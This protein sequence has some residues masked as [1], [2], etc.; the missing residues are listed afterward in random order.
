MAP[1]PGWDYVRDCRLSAFKQMIL[2][3]IRTFFAGR[4]M[5]GRFFV[6]AGIGFVGIKMECG[7]FS[8]V[9]GR[10]ISPAGDLLCPR[11][12]SRQNAAGGRRLEKH[13]V[14]LC[15]LPRTPVFS[16]GE[17]PRGCVSPSGAGEG[18]DTAP[19]AARCRS[20][21]LERLFAPTRA[22]APNF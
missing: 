7:D 20:L 9:R 16:T 5:G 18:Q 11:R 13:S 14:F 10:G 12:Q 17:P 19:R 6:V 15:R 1:V 21:F 2:R 3:E 22:I 4:P 8:C